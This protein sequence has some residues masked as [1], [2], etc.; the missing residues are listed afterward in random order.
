MLTSPLIDPIAFSIG[1]VDVHWYGLMY[2]AG[3][4]C[5]W[6]L[7]WWRAPAFGWRRDEVGEVRIRVHS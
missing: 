7:M 2:L 6:W 5:G 4:A 1:P 3:F